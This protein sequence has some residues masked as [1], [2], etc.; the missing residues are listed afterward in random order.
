MPLLARNDFLRL[1]LIALAAVLTIAGADVGGRIERR[2]APV[3]RDLGNDMVARGDSMACW[4]WQF[5]RLRDAQFLETDLKIATDGGDIIDAAA[6]V[7]DAS[8]R[9]FRRSR[10]TQPD[11][12]VHHRVVCV[13]MARTEVRPHQAA[14]LLMTVRYQTWHG[15]WPVVHRL[16]PVRLSAFSPSP[17]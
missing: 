6:L 15:L 1:M 3:I 5:I 7:G 4:R 10:T 12:L 16:R 13:D 14:T 2:L 17:D 11:G 9:Y 8:L